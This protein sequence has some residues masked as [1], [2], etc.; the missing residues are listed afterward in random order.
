MKRQSIY[1]CGYGVKKPSFWSLLES[2]FFG[3]NSLSNYFFI[4]AILSIYL[5]LKKVTFLELE[6]NKIFQRH[7]EEVIEMLFSWHIF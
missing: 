1:A 2:I 4:L 5:R 3:S 6:P 7:L